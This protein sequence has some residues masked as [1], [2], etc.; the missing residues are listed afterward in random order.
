MTAAY[1]W[2][3]LRRVPLVS[4]RPVSCRWSA[5]L[6]PTGFREGP[7]ERLERHKPKGLRA[8]LTGLRS[9]NALRL[10]GPGSIAAPR[11]PGGGG[12]NAA[13]PD[14][15]NPNIG[16]EIGRRPSGSPDSGQGVPEHV[17]P[18]LHPAAS[19]IIAGMTTHELKSWPGQFEAMWTGLKRAEFRRDDRGYRVGDT[20]WSCASGT[21]AGSGTRASG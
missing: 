5:C 10:P 18:H 15:R 2:C 4:P 1:C 16:P 8:V 11:L 17:R 14:S 19:L 3:G 6:R 7:W 20:R 12:G 21:R 9:S 13:S